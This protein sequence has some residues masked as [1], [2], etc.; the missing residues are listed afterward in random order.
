[1]KTTRSEAKTISNS[2]S[3]RCCERTGRAPSSLRHARNTL[4]VDDQSSRATKRARNTPRI[5]AAWSGRRVDACGL[6]TVAEE[7]ADSGAVLQPELPCSACRPGE[8]ACS[9][10]CTGAWQRRSCVLTVAYDKRPNP[11]APL[12]ACPGRRLIAVQLLSAR[13]KKASV[14]HNYMQQ[15]MQT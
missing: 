1:M 12:Q 10:G 3:E 14:A 15:P 9:V 4:R 6:P 2:S 7:P 13:L 8:G 11:C 5:R